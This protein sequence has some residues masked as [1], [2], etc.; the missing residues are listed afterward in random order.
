M[1]LFFRVVCV[2]GGVACAE[3]P[4]LRPVVGSA[5]FLAFQVGGDLGESQ[6]VT[7]GLL[8]PPAGLDGGRQG[9]SA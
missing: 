2:P 8:T 9:S 5:A 6:G 7:R 4:Y 3:W 1:P